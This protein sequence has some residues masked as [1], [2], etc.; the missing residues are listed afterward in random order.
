MPGEQTVPDG[1]APGTDEDESP[2]VLGEED[3][4]SADDVLDLPL[5]PP[6]PRPTPPRR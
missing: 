3:P 5:P 4:G 1:G 2:S 6:L